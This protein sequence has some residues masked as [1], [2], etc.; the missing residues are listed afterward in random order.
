MAERSAPRM[1]S[2]A[3]SKPLRGLLSLCASLLL[4]FAGVPLTAQETAS[5]YPESASAFPRIPEPLLPPPDAFE[6]LAERANRVQ[7]RYPWLIQQPNGLAV[8]ASGIS[9]EEFLRGLN[10][11]TDLVF[12]GTCE[13]PERVD[14]S[15]FFPNVSRILQNLSDQN[16]GLYH[17]SHARSHHVRFFR[18]RMPSELL[19]DSGQGIR[20]KRARLT[21]TDSPTGAGMFFPGTL[22]VDGTLIPPPVFLEVFPDPDNRVIVLRVNGLP[23]RKHPYT[24]PFN[25]NQ[26]LIQADDPAKFRAA[27]ETKA[28]QVWRDTASIPY[29]STRE[30]LNLTAGQMAY[31]YG[32]F[33][34]RVEGESLYFEFPDGTTATWHPKQAAHT[35]IETEVEAIRDAY[36]EQDQIVA[37]LA[38][39]SAVFFS[40]RFGYRV[41]PDAISMNEDLKRLALDPS[42]SEG[43]K[44]REI[45]GR[46]PQAAHV[47]LEYFYTTVLEDPSAS[48]GPAQRTLPSIPL[49]VPQ[50][51][52]GAGLPQLPQP[53]IPPMT[54][55]GGGVA[56]STQELLNLIQSLQQP[57]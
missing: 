26:E 16:P 19:I 4:A 52:P 44:E 31:V 39:G 37:A 33:R 46:W 50:P 28:A 21:G 15:G 49:P 53:A 51:P 17:E 40:Q 30:R 14:V 42:L 18:E 48:S 7:A 1:G 45:R 57:R 5:P 32:V 3:A 29:S 55:P 56:S 36:Q 9:R 22:V 24:S 12:D 2:R 38:G 27:L 43:E 20:Y 47:I 6:S 13:L 25:V 41:V 34:T 23:V 35:V 54:L 10:A 8:F 11:A